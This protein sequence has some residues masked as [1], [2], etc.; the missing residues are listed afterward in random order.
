MLEGKFFICLV[1]FAE[2]TLFSFRVSGLGPRG[3]LLDQHPSKQ[4]GS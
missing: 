1:T 4:M 3:N 2:V